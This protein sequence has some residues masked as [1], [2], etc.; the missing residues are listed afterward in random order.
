MKHF[1]V[2][3]YH[4]CAIMMNFVTEEPVININALKVQNKLAIYVFMSMCRIVNQRVRLMNYVTSDYV[5]LLMS[6]LLVLLEM[7]VGTASYFHAIVQVLW[8]VGEECVSM[9]DAPL[10]LV[11]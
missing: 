9:E 11:F 4:V 10:D 8:F 5:C 1:I 3:L 7:S 2:Y 6:A